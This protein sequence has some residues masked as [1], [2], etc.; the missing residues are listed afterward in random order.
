M[1]GY[2]SSLF[3][4]PEL[5]LIKFYLKEAVDKSSLKCL[6]DIDKSVGQKL[7]FEFVV[8]AVEQ[9]IK[10]CSSLGNW[11]DEK[12]YVLMKIHGWFFM[13]WMT[14]KLGLISETFLAIGTVFY[15]EILGMCQFQEYFIQVLYISLHVVYCCLLAYIF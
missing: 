1:N 11:R 10:D 14:T 12:D 9:C 15:S 6:K 5:G 2:N 7:V 13:S 3:C 4:T 8:P